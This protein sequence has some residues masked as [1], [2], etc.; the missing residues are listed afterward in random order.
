MNAGFS[1]ITKRLRSLNTYQVSAREPVYSLSAYLVC[2]I[3]RWSDWHLAIVPFDLR[4]CWN[5]ESF[6]W[7]DNQH[8]STGWPRHPTIFCYYSVEY[9][10]H[11][12]LQSSSR[13][14]ADCRVLHTLQARAY[15]QDCREELA[16]YFRRIVLKQGRQSLQYL[17]LDIMT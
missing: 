17:Q 9:C 6:T 10:Y 13:S 5:L 4:D 16:A 1:P 14:I 3:G 2:V 15:L 7:N 8:G 12:L 11:E